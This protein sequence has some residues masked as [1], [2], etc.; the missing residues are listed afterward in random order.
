MAKA[1]KSGLIDQAD[2]V[3]QPVQNV[4]SEVAPEQT[5]EA[6]PS[7]VLNEA[8]AEVPQVGHSSRAYRG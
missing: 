3:T 6:A 1:K 8:P 4:D 2:E 5:S 7:V